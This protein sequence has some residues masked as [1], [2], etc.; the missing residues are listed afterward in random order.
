MTAVTASLNPSRSIKARC[1]FAANCFEVHGHQLDPSQ[2]FQCRDLTGHEGSVIAVDF[3]ADGTL[4]ASGGVDKIVRLWPISK[5]IENVIQMKTKH[6]STIYCLAISSDN[7]RIISG[8]TDGKV[9]IH[10]VTT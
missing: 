3:S 10:D 4:L 1:S 7:R 5:S 6:K 8:E 2:K 9:I